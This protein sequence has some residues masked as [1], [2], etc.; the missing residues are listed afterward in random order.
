MCENKKTFVDSTPLSRLLKISLTQFRNYTFNSFD[1][2]RRITCI[3]GAN[4]CGKT[5]LLDA[6][7]Y[8][9][10]TKSYFTAQQQHAVQS[11][12]DGFRLQGTFG[13]DARPEIITCKWQQGKKEIAANGVEYDRI[14][15]HIGKYAAVMIAPDDMELINDGSELR[16]KWLDGILSQTD[17]LYFDHL[18]QYQKVLLQRNAWLKMEAIQPG[19]SYHALDFYNHQ[20]S[21]SGAYLYEKRSAFI[22]E[23]LPLLNSFYHQL[24]SGKEQVAMHYNSDL[25]EQS[26]EELLKQT[27]QH[28]LRLQRTSRGIHR[29][30]LQFMIGNFTLKQFGSQ[31]QK[32]S[33][34]FALKLAQYSYLSRQLRQLPI[35]LLD[36][37]FEKLD[38]SRMEA[39]LAIIQHPDFGQVLLTDTHASRVQEAFGDGVEIGQIALT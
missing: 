3:T 17:K 6:V 1:F 28:D 18:V 38:Q 11:G 37:I 31:G 2:T 34:L 4:G 16:R 8:L 19:N 39:L 35:L 24:A 20:L 21:K 12:T 10:Y 33:Y 27:I 15:D 13:N 7:Y 29:D 30:D 36:D 9:C 22:N 14:T 26:P 23:F 32:K 25:H 5:N